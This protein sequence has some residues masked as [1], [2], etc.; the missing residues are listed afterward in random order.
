MTPSDTHRLGDL[1]GMSVAYAG[2][3]HAGYVND[4]RLERRPDDSRLVAVGIV[5]GGRHP[6]SLLGY[7][8]RSEQGPVLVR[9]VVRWIHRHAGYVPWES[10]IKIDWSGRCVRLRTERLEP[11]D[12]A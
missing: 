4:V 12:T 6:G 3:G 8:R 7:D 9:W 2:G 11:L 10:V 1:L 5:V